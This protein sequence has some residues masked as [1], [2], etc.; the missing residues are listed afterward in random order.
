MTDLPDDLNHTRWTLI[1]RL[2]DLE[3]NDSWQAFFDAY[4]RLIYTV[5][6]TEI[7]MFLICI[8]FMP[9]PVYDRKFGYG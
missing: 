8:D 4:W 3:D 6:G 7:E 2:K 9:H 1:Q 5:T